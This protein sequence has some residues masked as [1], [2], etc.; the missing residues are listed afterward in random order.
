MVEDDPVRPGI[1]GGGELAGIGG[2]QLVLGG[3]AV[4][5]NAARCSPQVSRPSPGSAEARNP[6][7]PADSPKVDADLVEGLWGLA[8]QDLGGRVGDHRPP[9]IGGQHVG[10][11]LG[12]DGQPGP[13]LA[14]GFGRAQQELRPGRVGQQQ[15]RLIDGDQ[16]PPPV[17]RVRDGGPDGVQDQQHRGRFEFL[18]QCP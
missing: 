2:D 6:C 18:G 12:D 9:E 7:S 14:S 5:L 16:A 13:V 17:V 3:E 11:V 15:P 8:E 10:G 1:G 4:A